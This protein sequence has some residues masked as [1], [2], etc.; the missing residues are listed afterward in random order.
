MWQIKNID[1]PKINICSHE[2]NNNIQYSEEHP[3]TLNSILYQ[4]KI[5]R[6]LANYRQFPNP[7][8]TL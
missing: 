3:L 5:K 4:I 2:M 7:Q 8:S 6:S 1:K